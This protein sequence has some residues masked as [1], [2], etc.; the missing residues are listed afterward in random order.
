MDASLNMINMATFWRVN[1]AS[2]PTSWLQ[3]VGGELLKAGLVIGRNA[4]CPTVSKSVTINPLWFA[5][6]AA[7]LV[8]MPELHTGCFSMCTPILKMMHPGN[9]PWGIMKIT[10]VKHPIVCLPPGFQF[11]DL[12]YHEYGGM[13]HI[14]FCWGLAKTSLRASYVIWFLRL[15]TCENDLFCYLYLTFLWSTIPPMNFLV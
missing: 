4:L 10:F 12:T 14:R 13:L 3:G 9:K 15:I 5:I 8:P 2:L 1:V 7:Q 11:L 6:S